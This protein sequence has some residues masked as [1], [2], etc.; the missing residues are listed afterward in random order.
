MENFKKVS[1]NQ[2]SVDK[3]IPEKIITETY[4]YDFLVQRKEQLKA[5]KTAFI[6]DITQ[7]LAEVEEL[8]AEAKKLGIK[9]ID[10]L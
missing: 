5:E 7:K 4:D 9:S 8:I 2:I 10:I 1:D 6:K 3:V